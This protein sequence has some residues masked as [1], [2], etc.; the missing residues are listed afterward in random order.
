MSQ[1]AAACPPWAGRDF[2]T[3]QLP[4][5][6]SETSR[7]FSAY[8]REAAAYVQASA[9]GR[10]GCVTATSK[11]PVTRART[12]SGDFLFGRIYAAIIL[13]CLIFVISI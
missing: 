12:S 6:V 2:R 3:P 8:G 11:L 1:Y 9:K 5:D 7:R 10:R 13:F 4:D